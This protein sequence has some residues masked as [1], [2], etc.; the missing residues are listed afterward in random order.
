MLFSS[1]IIDNSFIL[2]ICYM[3]WDSIIMLVVT[4]AIISVTIILVVKEFNKVNKTIVYEEQLSR[5]NEST[6]TKSLKTTAS[7]LSTADKELHAALAKSTA[8]VYAEMSSADQA[9]DKKLNMVAEETGSAFLMFADDVQQDMRRVDQEYSAMSDNLGRYIG[10]NQT[11]NTR[12][13]NAHE[14]ILPSGGSGGSLLQG[15]QARIYNDPLNGLT[16]SNNN[17]TK[18]YDLNVPTLA[19]GTTLNVAGTLNFASNNSSYMLGVDG[20]SMYLKLDGTKDFTI[21]DNNDLNKLSVNHSNVTIDGASFNINN[22]SQSYMFN[23]EGRD[24]FLKPSVTNGAF[25]VRDAN[26]TSRLQ[27]KNED[28][29]ITGTTRTSGDIVTSTKLCINSTCL[30]EADIA[31]LKA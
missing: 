15:T 7:N 16:F 18:K 1:K 19:V 6:I 14:L 25:I 11:D 5:L 24:L 20:T 21:R 30:N 13:L 12:Y 31:K 28:V 2:G 26:N 17:P 8:T 29:T 23:L 10:S 4:L 22:P 27:V 3:A 9:F